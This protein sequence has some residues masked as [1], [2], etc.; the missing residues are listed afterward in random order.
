MENTL[1]KAIYKIRAN[2]E[3]EEE[4]FTSILK[5][6]VDYEIL[7]D[8]ALDNVRFDMFMPLTLGFGTAFVKIKGSRKFQSLQ[9]VTVIL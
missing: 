9:Y 6:R 5:F 4:E 2:A 3:E 7:M 1:K 8:N